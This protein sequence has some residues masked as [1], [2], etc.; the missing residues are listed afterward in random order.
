MRNE[1]ENV[2]PLIRE[3][4]AELSKKTDFEIVCID[5]GSD[6]TTEFELRQIKITYPS[7]RVI[8]HHNCCGQSTAISTGIKAAR[9]AW[10]VTLDGDGQNP[11]SEIPK[12]F[13][14]LKYNLKSNPTSV[15]LMIAGQR[16]ARKDSWFRR[17]CSIVANS[18]REIVLQDGIRDTGCSLKLFQREVFLNLPYFDHM[19][20]FMAP[21]A[22]REGATVLAMPVSHA[23]R[24]TGQSKY[25]NL[26][27]M[28]VGISDIFGVMWLIRRSPKSVDVK[29]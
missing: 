28:L 3:I 17:L 6:D 26:Q 15:P 20:R 4:Y 16:E 21:L 13:H 8:Q 18:L 24:Q 11:P 5:D 2:A 1:A 23:P 10:I 9:G 14:A 7:L 19:H 29:E 22:R 12:L 25:S 27:R